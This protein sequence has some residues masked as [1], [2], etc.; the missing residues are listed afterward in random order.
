[1]L[2]DGVKGGEYEILIMTLNL[3]EENGCALIG[4][5]QDVIDKIGKLHARWPSHTK[6]LSREKIALDVPCTNSFGTRL[7]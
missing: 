6:V 4:I 3:I 7:L 5:V 2:I 1:M